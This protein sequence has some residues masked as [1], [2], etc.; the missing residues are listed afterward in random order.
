MWISLHR[1]RLDLLGQFNSVLS[2]I[3]IPLPVVECTLYLA[4][5]K[6]ISKFFVWTV[7][8]MDAGLGTTVVICD[9]M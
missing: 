9:T 6:K 2:R 3:L 7:A 5:F 1:I 4:T 8:E